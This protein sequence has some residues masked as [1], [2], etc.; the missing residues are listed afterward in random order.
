MISHPRAVNVGT[1]SILKESK[2]IKVETKN[3]RMKPRPGQAILTLFSSKTTFPIGM[4]I[5]DIWGIP[6]TC[7]FPDTTIVGPLILKSK[8]L[9][10]ADYWIVY[11][12]HLAKKN[13]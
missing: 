5:K 10:G 13:D 7:T 2:R 11:C 4:L 9:F 12:D 8:V 3:Q 1:L 6:I